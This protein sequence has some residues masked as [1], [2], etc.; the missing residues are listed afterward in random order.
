MAVAVSKVKLNGLDARDE[1]EFDV[2]EG[3]KKRKFLHERGEKVFFGG[4]GEVSEWIQQNMIRCGS[5][6]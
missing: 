5:L 6:L 3:K 1:W 4:V 2:G